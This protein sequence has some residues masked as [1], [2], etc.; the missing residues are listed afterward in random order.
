MATDFFERQAAARKSTAWLVAMFG[1]GALAVVGFTSALSVF[2]IAASQE[3]PIENAITSPDFPWQAP[4]GVAAGTLAL[5]GGGSAFKMAMLR[6]HGG[7]GVAEGLG[8]K[9]LDPGSANPTERRLLNVVDEMAIASGVP[10]PPVFLLDERGIN[11]FAAGYSPS[12]AVIGVTR[13]CVE[14]LSRDELQ[15]VVA[16]EFSHILNGDM[17]MSIRMIGVLHGILLLGLIGQIIVRVILNSGIRIDSQRNSKEGAG[18][19]VMILAVL[20]AAICLIV[21]GSVGSFFGGLIKAAVSRQREFLADASAVQF[22]RNPGGIA[23]ALKRILASVGGSRLRHPRAAELS[24][25]YFSRGVWEGFSSLMATHPPLEKR[26]RAI[27]PTWD[28]T[29]GEPVAGVGDVAAEGASRFAGGRADELDRAPVG[30]VEHASQHVGDPRREHRQYAVEMLALAPEGLLNA[31]RE[32]YSAR[33]VVFVLLLDRNPAARKKQLAILA[34]HIDEGLRLVVKRLMPDADALDARLR[35]PLI[36]LT[37]PA[38]AAMSDR[39]Y[40]QFTRSFKA[41]VMADETIGLFEWTLSRVL[42]RHLRPKFEAVRDPRVEFSG[43]AQVAAPLSV[44][45]STLAYAGQRGADAERAF[46]AAAEKLPGV[47]IRLLPEGSC[48]LDPLRQALDVLSR[49]TERIRGQVIDAAAAA[50]CV[51]RQ[52]TVVEAE[53]LRGVSD[54]LDCPMPPLL[55][56]QQIVDAPAT[57]AR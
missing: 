3:G 10:A 56:G 14:S 54:L 13:G 44:L 33:A 45:M 30:A 22:T 1:V 37:L 49:T 43:L 35:L 7:A 42:L 5:V 11:A 29:V 25:M 16:H 20:V 6:A 36:D 57:A 34:E 26:I 15:G 38:L 27:E 39:Q 28:G 51:D 12:D 55:A 21:V 50:I 17:R 41:L 9:R 8:G 18:A 24:H 52:V 23:G 47:S 19:G 46:R 32:T 31:A 2:A 4:L 40:Q 53:L 48:G